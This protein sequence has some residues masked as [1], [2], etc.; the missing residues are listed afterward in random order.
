ML[1]LT[2][3]ALFIACAVFSFAQSGEL[4]PSFGNHGYVTA[5]IGSHYD[6][7][8]VGRQVFAAPDG[9]MYIIFNYPTYVSKRF[10][11]GSLDS[12][13]GIGGYSRSL[14]FSD[15][16][17]ALQADGKIV[18]AG[19]GFQVARI[20]ANGMVDSTFGVNGIHT[21]FNG[22][23]YAN[24][25]AAQSDGKILIAGTYYDGDTYFGVARLNSDGSPDNTFN[26]NG[27]V[28]TDF[29][30][31][32][33]PGKDQ[34]DSIPIHVQSATG[35]AVQPDGKIVAGG[36][37]SNGND[38]DFAVARYNSDGSPDSSFDGDGKQTT[39]FGYFDNA[40]S[41]AITSEGK[42]VLAGS[43]TFEPNHFAIARYNSDGSA[44]S[45]FNGNGKQ[46]APLDAASQVGNSLLAIQN[47]GKIVVAGFTLNLTYDFVIARF[48]INGS[49]DNTFDNDGI[50]NTD[51][52]SPNDFTSSD[53]F[54]GSVVI[55]NGDKILA[56]GYAINHSQGMNVQHLAVSRYN[57]DGSPD[58]SF[59][60][61]G[62]LLEDY[63]Q[64][65]TQL[66]ATAVQ[67]DGKIV[68][69]GYAWN[70]NNYDF[71]VARYNDK[72]IPDSSF[73]DDGKQLTDFDSTD[74]YGYAVAVQQ[75]GKI[76]VAGKSNNQFAVARYN[77]D[78]S[79]DNTFNGTGKVI[80]SI[81]FADNCNSIAL[82]ADGKIVLAGFSFI[83]TNY[84][85]AFY[86]IARLNSNGSPDNTFGVN[87]KKLTNLGFA[88]D[89]AN[90]IAIQTDGKI[91]ASGYSY[92]N[93]NDNF[94]VARFNTDGSLD[95]TFSEDGIQYNSFGIDDYFGE[96]LAVQN[97]GKII[98]AGYSQNIFGN[99]T[100]FAVARY[101]TDGSLDSSFGNNGFQSTDVGFNM[102]YGLS[103]AINGDGRIA[104]GG[105][106][107]NFAVVLYNSDGT[108][109]NTFSNDGI[110]ITN[111]GLGGSR[112]SSLAFANGKLYATGSGEFPGSL[113]VVARYLIAEGGP[114]P[115]TL[116]DFTGSLLNTSVLLHWK[117]A[118]EKN[119]SAFI[120]ERSGDGIHF[121]QIN[122]VPSLGATSFVRN[123]S[124]IDPQP[125]RGINFYR[126]K[127]VD[128]DGKFSY[129]NVVAVKINAN[130]RLLVFPNPA[131]RILFVEANGNE[132]GNFEIVDNAGRKLRQMKISL[133][134]KTSFSI[135]ISNLSSGIYNLIL[136]KKETTEIQKFLKE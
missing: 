30:F 116:L 135:D 47:N 126:L 75:D 72:G 111:I 35:V 113:G 54:A 18:V 12:A 98:V 102:E 24:S 107:D 34:T 89:F 120:I 124:I 87:S 46:T 57:N 40:Y 125:L 94:S 128:I 15:A 3:L 84:D 39:D 103:V 97:D 83:D 78:G 33:P 117:I 7:N 23:G 132:L 67:N 136:Y 52:T 37:A 66:N 22:N 13:Y 58:N 73:S 43:T 19:F 74:N 93:G 31:K 56:A 109:D 17:G 51:F 77:T 20:N 71:A 123:Y 122:S 133:N 62:K 81:G 16:Y 104:V 26:G 68:V 50:L 85:S 5:D 79:P 64:G 53:D 14:P 32:I 76:V 49:L 65:Y 2:L 25:V 27:E 92:V 100:A 48:N 41:L 110:Q 61:N 127:M 86:A 99:S 108:P 130:G 38:A 8:S 121:I 63:K 95:N 55:Q 10:A 114:V 59:N 4:D 91:I 9:G 21:S 42:I 131:K 80:F 60:G 70:G 28:I 106:N 88:K 44:D 90:S 82:Q 11:D 1:K 96:S 118:T 134:G 29:G 119:L 105:T 45:S 112:I 36:Y 129:S 6:Y 101:K 69:A 115:V